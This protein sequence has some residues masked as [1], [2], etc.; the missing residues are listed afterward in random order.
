M[1]KNLP[2]A[3]YLASLNERQKFAADILKLS[4][5]DPKTNFAPDFKVDAEAKRIFVLE[6]DPE[7]NEY[8]YYEYKYYNYSER[9]AMITVNDGDGEFRVLRSFTKKVAEEAGKVI[10]GEAIKATDKYS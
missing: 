10:T 6:Q 3:E 1:P 7:T 5:A 8:T 2:A 9:A 4:S